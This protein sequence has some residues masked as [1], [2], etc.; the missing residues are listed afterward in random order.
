[1]YLHS[2]FNMEQNKYD[3]LVGKQNIPR[4]VLYSVENDITVHFT[5]IGLFI[6]DGSLIF[7]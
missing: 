1:M 5:S 3:L 4:P 2:P 6:V 7:L